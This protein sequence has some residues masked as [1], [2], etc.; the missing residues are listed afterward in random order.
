ME[1]NGPRLTLGPCNYNTTT[2]ATK[3]SWATKA[4]VAGECMQMDAVVDSTEYRTGSM[5]LSL[6]R[7]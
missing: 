1:N 4:A 7:V 5:S 6:S 2:A 3:S